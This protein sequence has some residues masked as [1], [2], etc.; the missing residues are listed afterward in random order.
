MNDNIPQVKRA[1]AIEIVSCLVRNGHRAL[2]AGGYVRD[3]LL[4]REESGDIDIVTSATPQAVSELFAHTIGVGAQFGVVIV[5]HRG[6]PFEVATFRS[7]VGVHDGRHPAHIVFAGEE[8]DAARRDFTINGMFYDPLAD[9]IFDYVHGR[10]DLAAGIVR[11]VGEPAQRFREDW[12]R[13]LRAVRFAARFGFSIEPA[14]WEAVKANAA[15]IT[16]ISAERIFSEIERMLRQP[17]PDRAIKLL[18]E[19]GLLAAVLPEVAACIGVEQPAEFHPEGDVFAH[20]VKA[21]SLLPEQPSAALAWSVLLHDIG[22]RVTM[23]RADRIRFNNHDQAGAAMAQDLL[24]RLRAPNALIESVEACIAN[25]MHFM[26]VTAMRLST[27]KKML[28]RT[29]IADECELHRIDCLA[30]HGNIDNYIF[31]KKRLGEFAAERLRPAPLLRGSDL[32]A[33]G[34]EQGPLFGEILRELYDLQLDEKLRTRDEALAYVREK[35][36][37]H[38]IRMKAEG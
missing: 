16:G 10:E 14:T 33:L 19:S 1:A 26:N 34:F 18:A 31:V 25:H 22:K 15:S 21:L 24:K 8:Q 3:M 29:T 11:S 17:H 28:G 32:L 4:R 30:S 38:N 37:N 5:V 13:L 6:I 2:F 23:E 9:R 20:T 12:L 35:W 36:G 27:L 7:D